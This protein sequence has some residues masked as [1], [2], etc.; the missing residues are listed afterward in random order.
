M[1]G[2]PPKALNPKTLIQ[3]IGVTVVASLASYL[4]A[5]YIEPSIVNSVQ[6]NS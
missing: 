4:L 5:K 2:Q 6:H 1:S 3:V